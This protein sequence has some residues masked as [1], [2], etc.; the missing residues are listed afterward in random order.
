MV[1]PYGKDNVMKNRKLNR[2]AGYDYSQNGYY[3]I[4]ICTQKHK[5][6]FGK[7]TKDKV[8]LNKFGKIA[9]E[10]LLEIPEHFTNVEIDDYVIMP[11]HIHVI[12]IIDDGTVC[13]NKNVENAHIVGNNDRCS[14]HRNMELLPKV[15]SQYKSSVTRE[16]RKQFG[17][18]EF[19]WQKSYYDHVIH[20][21][22]RLERIRDYIYKNPLN[23]EKDKY[24]PDL[25]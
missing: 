24:Y 22:K 25:V 5:T 23:W 7:I 6:F 1:V 4:T 3:F 20:S 19:S 9:E 17:N 10:C 16:I 2:L 13:G 15:V 8:V 14:L 21:D 18:Y 12:I 11:N